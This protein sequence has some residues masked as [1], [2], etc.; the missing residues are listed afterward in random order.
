MAEPL[1]RIHK[2]P[3]WYRELWSDVCT[4]GVVLALFSVGWFFESAAMQWFAFVACFV[5]LVGRATQ[6][7][8]RCSPQEAADFIRD[9]YG[10]TADTPKSDQ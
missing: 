6:K 5:I 3:S 1:L 9:E 10:V 2:E 8:K 4:F 7:V